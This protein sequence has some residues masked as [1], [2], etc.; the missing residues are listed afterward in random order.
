MTLFNLIDIIYIKLRYLG[1]TLTDVI[2][3]KLHYPKITLFT[4]TYVI[5][6]KLRYIPLN[7][8][9]YLELLYLNL[10]C[11]DLFRLETDLK[12]PHICPKSYRSYFLVNVNL[13]NGFY[14]Q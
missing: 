10:H 6:L 2:Y 8:V 3:F 4:L 11:P 7:Y 5:Y 1:P 9:T 12:L 14:L 13:C